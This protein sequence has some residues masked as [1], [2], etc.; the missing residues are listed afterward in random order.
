MR[1]KNPGR[2]VLLL[3]AT[4]R[5]FGAPRGS[6]R[7]RARRRL[8][9]PRTSR[10]SPNVPGRERGRV[11]APVA[12][13]P[14]R[15]S[16]SVDPGAASSAR[17]MAS[18]SARPTPMRPPCEPL[19]NATPCSRD[20]R[21]SSPASPRSASP[22]GCARP[23]A[24]RSPPR[25]SPGGV[26]AARA[27]SRR[28]TYHPVPSDVRVRK[29][30]SESTS[31]RRRDGRIETTAGRSP[32]QTVRRVR[33]DRDT[34]RERA[35]SLGR[36]ADLVSYYEDKYGDGEGTVRDAAETEDVEDVEEHVRVVGASEATRGEAY[37]CSVCGE[38]GHAAA[39]HR[40]KPPAASA[41]STRPDSRVMVHVH[42]FVVRRDGPQQSNVSNQTPTNRR[43]RIPERRVWRPANRRAISGWRRK[44]AEL[45][46]LSRAR[47][48]ERANRLSRWRRRARL[49]A[50]THGTNRTC[51][52]SRS[53]CAGTAPRR[54]PPSTG[55]PTR[56][57][58]GTR[59]GTRTS[60]GW[61][62]E[63]R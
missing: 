17:R 4:R 59:T 8:R 56:T 52:A 33:R 54:E 58:T 63:Y 6:A 12:S 38:I 36:S 60:A 5:A 28:E 24:P 19:A 61:R 10:R 45:C 9:R 48:G 13:P 29:N 37:R 7:P 21:V 22:L 23:M 30:L 18:R 53:L 14:R 43:W 16:A 50:S 1:S 47:S 2:R 26:R 35:S 39:R 41:A 32:Y 40:E 34:T 20:S 31:N 51:T 57:G 44:A 25:G 49:W 42:V 15:P 11:P 46:L 27:E 55:S 62:E 3:A